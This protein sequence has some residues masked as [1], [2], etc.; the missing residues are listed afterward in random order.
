MKKGIPCNDLR[1]VSAAEC[2]SI[3]Y[4][5]VTE[6]GLTPSSCTVSL[7]DVDPLTGRP[8]TDVEFFREYHMA[9]NREAYYNSKAVRVP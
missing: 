6:D 8:I 9:A 1:K 7:S 4:T 3:V 2:N 5:F